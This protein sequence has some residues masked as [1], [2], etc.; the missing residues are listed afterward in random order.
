MFFQYAPTGV[1]IHF[2]S[3]SSVGQVTVMAYLPGYNLGRLDKSP[4]LYKRMVKKLCAT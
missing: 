3:E 4:E 1:H 2:F